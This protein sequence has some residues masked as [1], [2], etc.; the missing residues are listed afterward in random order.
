MKR[1]LLLIWRIIT[2][3]VVAVVGMVRNAN[4]A[5]ED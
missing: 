3:V 2:N 5:D 4:N 1:L